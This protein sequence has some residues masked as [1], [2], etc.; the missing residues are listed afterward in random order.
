MALV[1]W[2]PRRETASLQRQITLINR[3]TP[4]ARSS[5]SGL[6]A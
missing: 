4:D 6:K 3:P 2:N 1:Y 5:N